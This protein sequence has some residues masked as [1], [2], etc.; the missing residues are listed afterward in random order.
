M[1]KYVEPGSEAIDV[2][3]SGR[4]LADYDIIGLVQKNNDSRLAGAILCAVHEGLAKAIA[5]NSEVSDAL[6]LSIQ[7]EIPL[8]V[9]ATV[10]M[11]HSNRHEVEEI[12]QG[13]VEEFVQKIGYYE[14]KVT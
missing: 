12:V 7:R 4:L 8:H 2:T 3:G 14:R 9:Q 5:N 11:F 1:D 10:A 13:W 6:V